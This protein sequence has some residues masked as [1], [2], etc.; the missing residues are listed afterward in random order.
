MTEEAEV[1]R[2]GED[3]LKASHERPVLVDF[4]APWCGPCRALE[5]VLERV[6]AGDDRFAFV[7]VNVDDNPVTAARHGIRG[8]PAVRLYHRG[9]VVGEFTGVLPEAAVR[10]WLEGALPTRAKDLVAEARSLVDA[11]E[12]D[13][14]I[15]L[16]EEALAGGEDLPEGRALLAQALALRDPARAAALTAGVEVAGGYYH[17]IAAAVRTL[18]EFADR[19]AGAPFGAAL[20]ALRAGDPEE[21]IRAA[22]DT[23]RADPEHAEARRLLVALFV[24]LG[25]THDLTKAYRRRFDL[26]LW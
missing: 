4:W 10:Q 23:L 5:P 21:L 13:T 26:G 19:R 12:H 2:F 16:L 20:D 17:L 1:L 25:P 14:A 24:V 7:K 22:F 6:T 8:I 11:A 18:A 9:N 3:V 15:P